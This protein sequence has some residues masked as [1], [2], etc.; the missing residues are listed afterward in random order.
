MALLI[1]P[2]APDPRPLAPMAR[3]YKLKPQNAEIT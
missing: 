2:P 1:R 3:Y